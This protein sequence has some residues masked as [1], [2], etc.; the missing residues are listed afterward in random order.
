MR[1]LN[2][3]KSS[4]SSRANFS[5]FWPRHSKTS[6]ILAESLG[7]PKWEKVALA[8]LDANAVAG[9]D[10]CE[11]QQRGRAGTSRNRE[12]RINTLKTC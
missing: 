7:F 9:G 6:A 10:A 3:P 4:K 8:H 5:L 1:V 11:F 2:V 12:G